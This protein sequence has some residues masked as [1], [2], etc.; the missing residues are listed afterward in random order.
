MAQSILAIM[1][2]SLNKMFLPCLCHTELSA[3]YATPVQ[4]LLVLFVVIGDTLTARGNLCVTRGVTSVVP[5]SIRNTM[6]YRRYEEVRLPVEHLQLSMQS[7]TRGHIISLYSYIIY[8]HMAAT[9][10]QSTLGF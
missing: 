8:R 4:N 7:Y 1:L 3:L 2:L 5:L 6:H 9:S 10:I